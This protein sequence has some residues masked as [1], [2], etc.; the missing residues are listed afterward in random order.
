MQDV[1]SSQDEVARLQGALDEERAKIVA[2]EDENDVLAEANV[3]L[4]RE[5]A[6]LRLEL[7]SMKSSQPIGVAASPQPPPPPLAELRFDGCN[8]GYASE[9][10]LRI[11]NACG[12]M[13][14]LSL[15]FCRGTEENE[16]LLACGGT[17]NA[18][19]V[20]KLSGELVGRVPLSAPVLKLCA[21]DSF[22]AASLMDGGVAVINLRTSNLAVTAVKDHGKYVVAIGWR[23]DGR[24]LASASYDKSV[25][26]YSVA[27]PTD[28]A[29]PKMEKKVTVRVDSTPEAI[30]FAP[31]PLPAPLPSSSTTPHE[32]WELII[33]AR[34]TKDLIYL[35]C[36]DEDLHEA[37]AGGLP[38][39]RLVS[40][41]ESAWDDHV[42]F[43]PLSLALTPNAKHLLVATDHHVHFLTALGDSARVR[44]FVGHSC[45][46][47]GKPRVAFSPC[48]RF[49][50]SNSEGEGSI[51]VYDVSSCSLLRTMRGAHGAAVKDLSSSESGLLASGGFDRAVVLWSSSS[52]SASASDSAAAL[53]GAGAGGR[54]D[55]R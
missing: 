44:V 24:L 28:G 45:G 47:Y 21:F 30:L 34:D 32:G 54:G 10:K 4:E 49:L 48:G 27:L 46:E 14:V 43:A 52:N 26:L 20:Y 18:V 42:S 7:A 12:G 37:G 38:R 50:Y 25:N 11:E 5:L 19:S 29:A 6:A 51:L 31:A 23:Q 13:N 39:R 1:R 41:N 53:E 33:A 55:G 40:L 17:D 3:L 2:L 35:S 15:S 8:G 9:I 36:S 16:E 22:V